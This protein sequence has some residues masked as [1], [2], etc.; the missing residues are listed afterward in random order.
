M[1]TLYTDGSCKLNLPNKPGTCAFVVVKDNKRIIDEC[2][3]LEQNTSNNRME[4]TALYRALEYV[5]HNTEDGEEVVIYL[6][7]QYVREGIT[8]W[9]T[10]W[11]KNGWRTSN[12]GPVLNQ[13]LWEKLDSIYSAVNEFSG[14]KITLQWV[15]GHAN[16]Q[17]NNRADE[18]CEERYFKEDGIFPKDNPLTKEVGNQLKEALTVRDIEQQM[19]DRSRAALLIAIEVFEN[20]LKEANTLLLHANEHG[21][22][23]ELSQRVREYIIQNKLI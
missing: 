21:Y 4:I 16:N 23:P 3:F 9:I 12:K 8:K 14:N 18:L 5:W 6:D 7:S 15:K 10:T 2:S 19:E 13:D 1:I 11:K 20:K 17:Y 22:G